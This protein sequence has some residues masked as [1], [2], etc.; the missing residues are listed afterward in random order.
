MYRQLRRKG[1]NGTGEANRKYNFDQECMKTIW[2]VRE[3]YKSI[4]NNLVSEAEAKDHLAWLESYG[5]GDDD[6]TAPRKYS[7][8]S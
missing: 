4:E 3:L 5:I 2:N 1:E 8:D 6:K 7:K